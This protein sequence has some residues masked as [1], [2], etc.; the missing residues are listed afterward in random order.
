M[1][2]K[3]NEAEVQAMNAAI[4]EQKAARAKLEAV[5]EPDYNQME[6]YIRSMA[7]ERPGLMGLYQNIDREDSALEDIEIDPRL[8]DAQMQALE[9][10]SEAAESGLTEEDMAQRRSLQREVNSNEQARQK[11][12]LSDMAQRG[13]GG[14]GPELIARLQSSQDSAQNAAEAGDRLAMD[15]AASRRSALQQIA[16]ASTGMRSQEYGEKSTAATARDQ[17]AAFNAMN[18]QNTNSQN[19]NLRQGQEDQRSQQQQQMY[20]NLGNLQQQQFGNEMQKAGAYVNATQPIANMT[21]QN[22]SRSQGPGGMIGTL[23]GA[24]IGAMSGTGAKGASVGAQLGGAVGGG[25]QS[26]NSGN[27]ADGGL[28]KD[29]MDG[30]QAEA[31]YMND[32]K[33]GDDPYKKAMFGERGTRSTAESAGTLMSGL[34]ELIGRSPKANPA[35]A[36][37]GKSDLN[38]EALSAIAGQSNK[39]KAQTRQVNISN[40]PVVNTKA[41]SGLGSQRLIAA[42]GGTK[43]SDD[44][45]KKLIDSK[46][47]LKQQMGEDY[48][49][50]NKYKKQIDELDKS[51]IKN[52]E[53]GHQYNNGGVSNGMAYNDGGEGTIIDSGT[54]SFSG[55]N[56]PD[57]INDGEMVL[58]MEQQDRINDML[59]DYK[60]LKSE[61]RTDTMVDEGAKEVNPSQQEN[62]MAVARGELEIEDLPNER[63]VKEPTGGMGDLMSM[64]SK[65]KR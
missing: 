13:V 59:M 55:D 30:R 35:E 7:A 56:L 51:I 16:N 6:D 46:T 45:L 61:M 50:A 8:K 4:A 31:D 29:Q 18:R 43:Y 64:L 19:L 5:A 27:F 57:R 12:I 32:Q 20:S 52:I 15:Q 40:A 22:V 54:D 39:P 37:K 14:S 41:L 34:E 36:P 26:N 3:T 48:Y 9:G 38:M 24:G 28:S 23:V 25:M 44:N 47:Q 53:K 10:L 60:R 49:N 33:F 63:I 21:A 65:R 58:N 42:D 1:G 17:I 11:S 2:K 62:L